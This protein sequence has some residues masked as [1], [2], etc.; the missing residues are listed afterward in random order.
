LKNILYI[1][2]YYYNMI[3]MTFDPYMENQ[4]VDYIDTCVICLI[5]DRLINLKT[6]PFFRLGCNCSCLIHYECLEKYYYYNETLTNQCYCPICRNSILFYNISVPNFIK[7]NNCIYLYAYLVYIYMF[8]KIIRHMLIRV[9]TFIS[10]ILVFRHII[11]FF[12]FLCY[13]CPQVS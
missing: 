13:N 5:S 11:S 1:S 3:F 6:Q 2:Y 10:Y 9:F 4:P 7:Y 8:I 12:Y